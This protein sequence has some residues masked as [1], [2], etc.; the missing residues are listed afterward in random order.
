MQLTIS[1]DLLLHGDLQ[2]RIILILACRWVRI[3]PTILLRW[4]SWRFDIEWIARV[5]GV[6]DEVGQFVSF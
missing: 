6:I 2:L 4:I 5:G 1:S 3:I